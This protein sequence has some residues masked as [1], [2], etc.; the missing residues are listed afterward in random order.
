MGMAVMAG[1]SKIDLETGE[2]KAAS[3]AATK[4]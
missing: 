3:R 4:E 1:V 2:D